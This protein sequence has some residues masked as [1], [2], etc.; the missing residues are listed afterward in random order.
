MCA[1]VAA[2]RAGYSPRTARHQ[3]SRLLTRV[4][5]QTAL[6]AEIAAIRERT[7]ISTDRLVREIAAI[8]FSRITDVM[9]WENNGI[10]VKPSSE[11]SQGSAIAVQRV[12]MRETQTADGTGRVA[13]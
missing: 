9:S 5:I 11:L 6:A 10:V 8:A 4:N 12:T 2:T 7:R 13:S 1:T 3:G